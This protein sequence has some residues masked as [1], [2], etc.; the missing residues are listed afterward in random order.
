MSWKHYFTTSIGKKLVMG[1]TGL[2]LIVF[3]IVHAYVNSMIFVGEDAFNSAADF[4]GTTIAIRIME[5]GLFAGIILHVVQGYMLAQKNMATRTERYAVK[6][7]NKTSAWYSRSMGLLGTLILLFL[8]I[9]VAHFWVPSRITG[10]MEETELVN[11]RTTHNLYQKMIE[12]F[13]APWVVVVYLLGVFSLAWHL[14]HGFYSAF[15]TMGLTTHKYK[16]MIRNIGIVF[17][18]VICLLFAAMPVSMFMGWV[19]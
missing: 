19:S 16:K 11:G 1:F 10:G 4:M 14:V 13:Q 12:V 15:Q 3:L 17:S 6:P 18:I 7:G 2:F 8:V 9:H 5:V